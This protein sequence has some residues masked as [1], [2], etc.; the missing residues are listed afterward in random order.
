[1]L[2]NCTTDYEAKSNLNNEQIISLVI[3]NVLTLVTIIITNSLEIY[4]LWKTKQYHIKSLQLLL[5]LSI[6]DLTF[7]VSAETLFIVVLATYPSSTNCF[8]ELLCQFLFTS[9]GRVSAYT[10]ILIIFERYACIVNLRQNHFFVKP[11]F[12]KKGMAFVIILSLCMGA[13]S[14][15]GAMHHFTGIVQIT[16]VAVDFIV[17]VIGCVVQIKSMIKARKHRQALQN[18]IVLMKI[19]KMHTKLT[20]IVIFTSV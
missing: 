8:L 15:L 13:M 2:V 19:E 3:I 1:M 11:C 9:I 5:M 4:C 17:F 14:V 20:Y 7:G 10:L 6:A 18:L 16:K 12:I